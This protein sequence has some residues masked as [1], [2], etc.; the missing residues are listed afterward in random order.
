MNDRVVQ[1]VHI[2][3]TLSHHLVAPVLVFVYLMYTDVVHKE[4]KLLL[5]KVAL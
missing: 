5:D 3:G 1:R 2:D 4:F